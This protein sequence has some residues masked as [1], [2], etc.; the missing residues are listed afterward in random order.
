[1]SLQ[2]NRCKLEFIVL[3]VKAVA[4]RQ[5]L[6]VLPHVQAADFN[7]C[8]MGRDRIHKVEVGQM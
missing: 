2:E 5:V 6:R 3:S 8:V 1:M 7:L 4:E